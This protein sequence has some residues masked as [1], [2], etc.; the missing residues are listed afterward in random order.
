VQLLDRIDIRRSRLSNGSV[1][2]N[3]LPTHTL[4]QGQAKPRELTLE[5]EISLHLQPWSQQFEKK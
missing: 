4:V 3:S 2:R 5:Q 1:I